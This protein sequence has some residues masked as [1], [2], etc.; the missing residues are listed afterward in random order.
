M[1]NT[2]RIA[3]SSYLLCI[4]LGALG[5]LGC[6]ATAVVGTPADAAVAADNGSPATDV[7]VTRVDVPVTRVDVPV[8]PLVDRPATT[9]DVP[10]TMPMTCPLA[11]RYTA[12]I[13]G[14]TLWFEFTAGGVWRAAQD[15]A[16][17]AAPLIMGTYSV[18]DGALVLTGE[19]HPGGGG[20]SSCTPSDRGEFTLSFSPDC[21][22]LRLGLR[23]D[24]CD[25]RG[26]TLARLDFARR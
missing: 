11:G 19:T 4:T 14:T 26:E 15:E 21:A 22:S 25:D 17:L 16:G 2:P 1:L 8:G 5:T 13:E 9:P 6:G 20:G 23:S 3:L 12:S 24:D 7:P 18:A 10:P